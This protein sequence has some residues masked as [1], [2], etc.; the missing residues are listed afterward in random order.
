MR[1]AYDYW[2]THES[3]ALGHGVH[4][5]RSRSMKGYGHE[6]C[7]DRKIHGRNEFIDVP[8]CPMGRD[9]GGKIRHG[10]L[11]EVEHARAANSLDIW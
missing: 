2:N 4:M 3:N 8:Y 11:L 9:K 6:V 7:L 10:D 5:W 1:S